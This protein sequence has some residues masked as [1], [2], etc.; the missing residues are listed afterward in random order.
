MYGYLEKGTP[1]ARGRSTKSSRKWIRN[2][3]VSMVDLGVRWGV[4]GECLTDQGRVAE[5]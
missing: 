2:R 4:R 5:R 3:R 1:L